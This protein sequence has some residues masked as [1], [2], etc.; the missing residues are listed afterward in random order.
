MHTWAI[1]RAIR[2]WNEMWR[3]GKR[4][5]MLRAREMEKLS[6]PTIDGAELWTRTTFDN[7]SVKRKWAAIQTWQWHINQ[8]RPSCCIVPCFCSPICCLFPDF[9]Y[10]QDWWYTVKIILHRIISVVW[11]TNFPSEIRRHTSPRWWAVPLFPEREKVRGPASGRKP[12]IDDRLPLPCALAK[13]K[14]PAEWLLN[15]KLG[16]LICTK[17]S[18]MM[19]SNLALSSLTA[20]IP[21]VAWKATKGPRLTTRLNSPRA[22]SVMGVL[23]RKKGPK[24]VRGRCQNLF[25]Q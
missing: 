18:H 22:T 4:M 25:G 19:N 2:F 10:G 13:E 1:C 17:S 9:S 24:K 8:D 7:V 16:L 12:C 3:K 5:P 6:H 20:Q 21:Q 15:F 11:L 23:S 14:M